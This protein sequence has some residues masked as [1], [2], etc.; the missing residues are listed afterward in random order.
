MGQNVPQ[1]GADVGEILPGKDHIYNRVVDIAGVFQRHIPAVNNCLE[2]RHH[3]VDIR[4]AGRQQQQRQTAAVAGVYNILRHL[5]HVG[6][7]PQ[8]QG[9]HVL[10]CQRVDQLHPGPGGVHKGK[11]AGN[12][13]LLPLQELGD[14]GRGDDVR[15]RDLP[16]DAGGPRQK[17]R[18]LK[19]LELQNVPNCQLHGC[20]PPPPRRRTVGKSDRER[21]S[22]P[23]CILFSETGQALTVQNFAAAFVSCVQ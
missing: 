14:V 16:V 6:V 17:N 21:A 7:R 15:H 4:H 2:N 8:G 5:L 22:L 10:F 9:G 1:Q 18:L 20:P 3:K 19:Y 13:Q 12:Q 11:A 23:Y